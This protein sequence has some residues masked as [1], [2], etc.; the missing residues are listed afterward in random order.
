M[1]MRPFASTA[2]SMA[3]RTACSRE[4]RSK[5]GAKKAASWRLSEKT[6]RL[7]PPIGGSVPPGARRQ[8]LEQGLRRDRGDRLVAGPHRG[9]RLEVAVRAMSAGDAAL[10]HAALVVLPERDVLE[11]DGARVV[12]LAGGAGQRIDVDELRQV[13][14]VVLVLLL[15]GHAARHQPQHVPRAGARRSARSPMS[16]SQ[17]SR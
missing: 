12:V 4:V 1:S 8:R 6:S 13:A 14:A 9:D 3:P 17:A 11:R 15:D 10:E 5:N 16:P 2:S 7:R